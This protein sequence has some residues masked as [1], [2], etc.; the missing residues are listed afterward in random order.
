MANITSNEKNESDEEL[1]ELKKKTEIAEAKKKLLDAENALKGPSEADK[2]KQY[3]KDLKEILPSSEVKPLE[4]KIIA[5]DKV[6]MECQII[7]YKAMSEI[8]F[9]I[10]KDINNLKKNTRPNKVIIFNKEE[11]NALLTYNTFM[12]Q[13]RLL[14]EECEKAI[15]PP[16]AEEEK[17]KR[18]A[19]KLYMATTLPS[20]VA[21]ASAI[22]AALK[23]VIDIISLFRKNIEI[24]GQ[25]FAIDNEAL[26]AEVARGLNLVQITTINPSFINKVPNE[27]MILNEILKLCALK[28]KIDQKIKELSEKQTSLDSIAILKGLSEE[29]KKMSTYLEGT[30]EESK[31]ERLGALIKSEILSKELDKG[32]V[33]ILYLKVIFSG[34]NNQTTQTLF[35]SQLS[36]SGGAIITYFLLSKTGDIKVSKTFYNTIGYKKFKYSEDTAKLNNF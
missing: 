18:G 3:I 26:I 29:C 1:K 32:D 36:H 12:L 34:G 35:Q 4:G 2:I 28:E 15:K 14:N 33:D 22:P 6:S 7:T 27:M 16:L 10:A 21:A 5:D 23:A 31:I 11:F 30:D 9:Q 25:T 19:A 17:E 13:I 20:M 8:A 24:K